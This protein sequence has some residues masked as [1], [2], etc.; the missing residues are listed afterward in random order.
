VSDFDLQ[1]VRQAIVVPA[2]MPDTE[3]SMERLALFNADGT[4]FAGGGGGGVNAYIDGSIGNYGV[5]GTMA[6]M[7]FDE[8]QPNIHVVGLERA[9]QAVKLIPGVYTSSWHWSFDV[10]VDDGASDTVRGFSA[11]VQPL[12]RQLESYDVKPP[13]GWADANPYARALGFDFVVPVSTGLPNSLIVAMDA[14]SSDDKTVNFWV[15]F[16]V[17]R[18]GNIPT[19]APPEDEGGGGEVT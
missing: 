6:F 16:T 3:Q 1:D 7:P 15:T 4:P 11:Q 18:L 17:I 14:S 8:S 9:D 12:G 13:G 19:E 5:M 10:T 2:T